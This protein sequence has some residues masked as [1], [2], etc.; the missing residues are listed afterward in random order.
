MWLMVTLYRRL[1]HRSFTVL[2]FWLCLLDS[3]RT[4]PPSQAEGIL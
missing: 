1:V 2:H 3:P 4:F